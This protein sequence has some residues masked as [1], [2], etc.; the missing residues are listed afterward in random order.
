MRDHKDGFLDI[1]LFRTVCDITSVT[2]SLDQE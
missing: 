1:K 2:T